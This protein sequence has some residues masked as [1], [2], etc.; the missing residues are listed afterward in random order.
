VGPVGATGS[1]VSPVGPVGASDR[2]GR[3]GERETDEIASETRE[4]I[5]S[6]LSSEHD[7]TFRTTPRIDS[8]ASERLTAR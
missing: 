5:A 4:R 6:R 8:S 1:P 3:D 2:L 7:V